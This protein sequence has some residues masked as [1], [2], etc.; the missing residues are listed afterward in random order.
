MSLLSVWVIW[1]LHDKLRH[2]S[3]KCQ[4][5]RY[6]NRKSNFY[7]LSCNLVKHTLKHHEGP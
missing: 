2:N 7:F 4:F 1:V 5:A 6:S 3:E